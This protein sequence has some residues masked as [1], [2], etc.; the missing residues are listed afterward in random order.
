MFEEEQRIVLLSPYL[1]CVLELSA[2]QLQCLE[3]GC[4]RMWRDDLRKDGGQVDVR[5]E[6]FVTKPS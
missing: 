4:Y 5:S 3:D 1:N 2:L 6:T